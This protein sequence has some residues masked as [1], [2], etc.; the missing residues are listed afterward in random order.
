VA[1]VI[2][3]RILPESKCPVLVNTDNVVWAQHV[4]IATVGPPCPPCVMIRMMDGTDIY[5]SEPL[6]EVW[7]ELK[8]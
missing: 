2:L 3:T 5:V 6:N 8:G 1:L 4:E 7:G